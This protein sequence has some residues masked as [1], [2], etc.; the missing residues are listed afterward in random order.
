MRWN[1]EVAKRK[2]EG[3]NAGLSGARARNV[4]SVL[5]SMMKEGV[6]VEAEDVACAR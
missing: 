5:T 1:E 2:K 6:H 3:G 4:W